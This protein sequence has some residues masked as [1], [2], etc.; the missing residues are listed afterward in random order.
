MGTYNCLTN[1]GWS[2]DIFVTTN[3]VEVPEIQLTVWLEGPYTEIKMAKD[4]NI[5]GLLPLV[6]PYNDLPWNYGG[7]ESVGSIPG[8]TEDIVDWIYLEYRDAVDAA[9]ATEATIIDRAIGFVT[10][11]GNIVGLDGVSN[12]FFSSTLTNNL[13]VVVYH[14]NHLGVMSAVPLTMVGGVYVY[15]FTTSAGQAYNNNQI[16]LGFGDFGM[17]GGDMNADGT[18]D[19]T[20]LSE[21]WNGFA[22][23]TGYLPA[24]ANMDG[25]VG[26]KDKNDIW[27]ANSGTS[28]QIPE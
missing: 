5:A 27:N 1:L 2:H 24:D 10:D 3:T 16:H 7:T 9:S 13:F 21:F 14:R 25:Q 26:N 19:G 4:L 11:G 23:T 18:I 12:L 28:A 6:Q 17:Y 20:D 8:G 15:D 22:G